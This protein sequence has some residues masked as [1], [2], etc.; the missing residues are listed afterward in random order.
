MNALIIL[1]H[2]SRRQES[3][4]EIQH[5]SEK[6]KTIAA[7]EY[8]FI[9]YAYLELAEPSLLQ[10]INNAINNGATSITVLPYFLNSGKHLTQHIPTIIKTA[11]EKY[12]DCD[13]TLSANIGLSEDMPKLILEQARLR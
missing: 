5:L 2:G 4:L 9:E 7:A 3:N 12:P 6:V 1:A 11:I 13:I 8:H 10:S